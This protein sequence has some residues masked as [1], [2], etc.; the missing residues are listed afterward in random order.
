MSRYQLRTKRLFLTYPQCTLKKEEALPLLAS[1]VSIKEYVIAEEKHQNGD[2]HLHVYLLLEDTLST[3]NPNY[4]DIGGFHGNYQ[5]CRSEKNVVKYCTKAENFISNFDVSERVDKRKSKKSL[6]GE[7]LIQPNLN[8]VEL[9]KEYPELIYDYTKIKNNLK[10][11]NQDAAPRRCKLP[12]FLPNPFGKILSTNLAGK[13]R[14]YWIWSSQ[15]NKG[16]TTAAK[17]WHK[18][19]NVHLQSGDFTYWTFNGDEEGLIIDEYNSAKLGWSSLNAICDGT[20]SYRI[21]QGGLR[22][23]L[24]FLVIIFSNKPIVELYPNMNLFLYERFNEIELV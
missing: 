9:V 15:P 24:N 6:I 22:G 14:H 10:I 19:F 5:S 2:D 17:T 4:L 13:R 11:F 16:K 21:F 12:D 20:F 3:S 1:K 18:S 8:L 23:N 7:K